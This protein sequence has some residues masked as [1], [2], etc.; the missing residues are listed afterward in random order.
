MI[1][2][3]SLI[4][5]CVFVMV[6]VNEFCGKSDAD[7]YPMSCS[8]YCHNNPCTHFQ[9]RLNRENALFVDAYQI[10]YGENIQWLKD[11]PLGLSYRDMNILI[12]VILYPI[13]VLV[14]VW[15]IIRKRRLHG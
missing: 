13:M 15:G 7:Y 8:R 12:Y 5:F 3:L 9:N 2:V 11:N 10:A 14:L 6:A 4:L 1:R